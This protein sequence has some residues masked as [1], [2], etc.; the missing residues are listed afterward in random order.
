MRPPLQEKSGAARPTA[1]RQSGLDGL[2]ASL[3][4]ESQTTRSAHDRGMIDVVSELSRPFG[5][6]AA[7]RS[8]PRGPWLCV[9]ASRRVC[10]YRG[11]VPSRDVSCGRNMFYCRHKDTSHLNAVKK[12]FRFFL[13]LSST[14]TNP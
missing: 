1:I 8:C 13:T 3:S 6:L 4:W 5:N 9:P 2:F 11:R 14:L 7:Q 10:L 12:Y